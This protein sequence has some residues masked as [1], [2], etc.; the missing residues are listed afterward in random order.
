MQTYGMEA[1]NRT[2][3]DKAEEALAALAG[4]V[5][6]MTPTAKFFHYFHL[7]ALHAGRCAKV[8]TKK[9]VAFIPSAARATPRRV[10]PLALLPGCY[11]V[12]IQRNNPVLLAAA[13]YLLDI[14]SPLTNIK[15]GSGRVEPISNLSEE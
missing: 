6:S 3:S 9:P 10:L 11:C 1:R 12:S 8:A 5:Y 4:Q 13:V 14:K 2:C 7:E 15:S